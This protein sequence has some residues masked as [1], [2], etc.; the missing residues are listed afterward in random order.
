MVVL[1]ADDN[2]RHVAAAP[3]SP[4]LW[5]DAT[6]PSS[7]PGSGTTWTDLSG[8]NRNGTLVGALTYNST[9]KSVQFPGAQT[10][11]PMSR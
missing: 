8:N 3:P 11:L 9:S 4:M 5:L 1:T 7:Y 10:E 2:T 6:N